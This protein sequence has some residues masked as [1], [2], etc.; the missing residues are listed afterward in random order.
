MLLLDGKNL[1]KIIKEELKTNIEKY[2]KKPT[3]AVILVGNDEASK[4]YVKNKIKSCKECGIESISYNFDE[5]DEMELLG[6]IQAL[7]ND[8]SINGILVQLPLPKYIN[9]N[10]IIKAINPKKDVDGF[11][12]ENI[13]GVF[14]GQSCLKSCTP[15]GIIKL[16]KYHNIALKGQ[17]VV[18]VGASNIVGKPLALMMINEGATTSVCRS[19][20]KD[21][22]LYT[23]TA[24]IIVVATGVAKLLKKDMIKKGAVIVDVGINK[25]DGKL[26][27]DVDF[28]SVSSV[29]SAITPVP[30]GVGPMTIAS[31]MQNTYQAFLEQNNLG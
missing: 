13:A 17:N 23:K 19:S 12:D 30:G 25:I 24:D 4:V 31:L 16:L 18:I 27:G 21:I 10:N 26:V 29:A 5:I 9:Q 6:L 11:C 3:L 7:N 8:K 20:T 14:L 22:S 28:D 2:D 1:S 15:K